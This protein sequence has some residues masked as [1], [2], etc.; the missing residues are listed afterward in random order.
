MCLSVSSYQPTSSLLTARKLANKFSLD[1]EWL[2]LIAICQ[3][4]PF[5]VKFRQEYPMLHENTD[6]NTLLG[7]L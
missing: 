1:L 2:G 4:I 3:C 6:L 7:T 5:T